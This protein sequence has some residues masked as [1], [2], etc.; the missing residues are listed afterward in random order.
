VNPFSGIFGR[1]SADPADASLRRVVRRVQRAAE[2]GEPP[3][4]RDIAE[5][6]AQAPAFEADYR[7]P[8]HDEDW[9]PEPD[10]ERPYYDEADR[11][12]T[13]LAQFQDVRELVRAWDTGNVSWD[14]D[15]YGPPPDDPNCLI[16]WD[17]L[18]EAR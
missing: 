6:E 14:R 15:A 12:R 3:A 9:Q 2:R 8:Y 10:Y 16:P 5:L 1:V 7:T 4:E 13:N 11:Q 17:V 18:R